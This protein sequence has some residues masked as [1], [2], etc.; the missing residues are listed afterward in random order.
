MKV[1]VTG[2]KGFIG[3]NLVASLQ[4]TSHE[5]FGFDLGDDFPT[6]KFDVIIHLAAR[7]LIRKSVEL[8]YAYFEDDLRLTMRFLE[9]A[10]KENSKFVFPSS[11]STALP[12][13]PYAL[14]KKQSVE[15]ID[16]YRRLYGMIAFDLKFFNIYGRGSRKGGVYLFTKMALDGGPIELLGD[17]EDIRDFVYV[18]DVVS[19]LTE[20]VDGKVQPGSYEVGTGVG[21]SINSLAET[22][23]KIVGG[24]LPIVKKP[25]VID[26]ARRLVAS[27]PVLKN[28]V[29]LEDGIRKVIDFIRE[30]ESSNA[31]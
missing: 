29:K 2:H 7:G 1:L 8:P 17:G 26:T 10:R 9:K 5:V 28:P 13:N 25:D 11:G 23:A 30:D 3:S 6:G 4:R 27:N 31:V 24:G 18:S 20:I 12:S 19:L 14:S 15:W 16:L 21:T 22:V